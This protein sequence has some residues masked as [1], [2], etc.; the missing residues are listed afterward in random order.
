[1]SGV[2]RPFIYTNIIVHL[3]SGEAAKASTAESLIAGGGIIST[4]Y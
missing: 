1:M 2:K 4:R 3:M